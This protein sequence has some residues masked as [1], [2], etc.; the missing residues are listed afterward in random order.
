MVIGDNKNVNGGSPGFEA[1][2]KALLA[3]CPQ[4]A[5]DKDE[6]LADNVFWVSKN[7]RWSNLQATRQATD[8]T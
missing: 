7:A 3:E 5:E 4:D 6:Y 8:G 2:H 1:R